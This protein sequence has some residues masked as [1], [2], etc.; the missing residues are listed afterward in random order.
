MRTVSAI[1]AVRGDGA[2]VVLN[3]RFRGV[4]P[5]GSSVQEST[6]SARLPLALDALR[7]GNTIN[8]DRLV[9]DRQGIRH[10][11][12]PLAWPSIVYVG[13]I[14]GVVWTKVTIHTCRRRRPCTRRWFPS[15]PFPNLLLLVKIARALNVD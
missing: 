15:R 9:I 8:F 3:N 10:G 7:A 5:L 13:T 6:A 2:P 12:R 11:G 4:E 1:R 14:E